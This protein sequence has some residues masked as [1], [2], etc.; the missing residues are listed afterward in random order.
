MLPCEDD[1]CVR[2]DR[3]DVQ[4]PQAQ[5]A[6]RTP[7]HDLLT[8]S[9]TGK[10]CTIDGRVEN[11]GGL[12]AFG[13][14]GV[15][16][17]GSGAFSPEALQARAPSTARPEPRSNKVEGSGTG[18][19]VRDWMI[20]PPRSRRRLLASPLSDRVN[21]GPATDSG[22]DRENYPIT[23]IIELPN[24]LW[25]CPLQAAPPNQARPEPRRRMVAGSGMAAGIPSALMPSMTNVL[26]APP[27]LSRTRDARSTK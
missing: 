1:D 12:H 6:Q 10:K 21:T 22:E 23:R 5:N 13:A 7:P 4:H 3:Q 8:R 18:S 25:R 16:Y 19:G 11:T 15:G 20:Q 27:K 2:L 26:S 9:L 14:G 24:Y 17:Q